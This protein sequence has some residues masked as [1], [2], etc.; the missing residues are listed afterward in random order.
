MRGWRGR[1]RGSATA[2]VAIVRA[3]VG[4]TALKQCDNGIGRSNRDDLKNLALARIN[5]N[6]RLAT[7]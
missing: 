7:A 2:D 5:P 3:I 4:S 1:N 6:A